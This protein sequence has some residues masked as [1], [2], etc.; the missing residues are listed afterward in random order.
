MPL[1]Q[2]VSSH[3]DVNLSPQTCFVYASSSSSSSSDVLIIDPI[4]LFNF[5]FLLII[6]SE[7]KEIVLLEIGKIV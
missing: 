7:L 4:S 3:R 2:L 5:N 6:Y 1:S